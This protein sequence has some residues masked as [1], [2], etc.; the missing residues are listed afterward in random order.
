[1]RFTGLLLLSAL[2][3]AACQPPAADDYLE[4][5]FVEEEAPAASAPIAS[6]DTSDAVWAPSAESERLLYGLP[7]ETPLMA[8][9]C[10]REGETARLQFTRFVRADREAQAMLSLVGNFHEERLPVDAINNGRAWVWQG[11]VAADSPNL[12]ALT[13]RRE[14]EATIPGAGSVDLKPSPLLRELVDGCAASATP[15]EGPQ[16]DEDFPSDEAGAPDQ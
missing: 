4:R 7:G 11:S 16:A 12:A 8:V 3:L 1:M 6:P 14:A 15:P 5:G 2:P 13:G 9:Q 10:L